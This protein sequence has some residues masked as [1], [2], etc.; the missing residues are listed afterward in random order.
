MARQVKLT[1]VLSEIAELMDCASQE[2]ACKIIANLTRHHGNT[3]YLVL[4]DQKI[5]PA[6]L[7][8]SYSK[9][10]ETRKYICFALQNL[11][12]DSCCRRELADTEDFLHTLCVR[13]RQAYNHDERLA[14]IY[15][16]KNLTEEPGTLIAMSSTPE[17]FPTLMQIADARDDN[18]TEMMRYIGCDALANLSHWFRILA[19]KAKNF[20]DEK[21]GTTICNDLLVPSLNQI[22]WEQWK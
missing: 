5:V 7:K 1:K 22:A 4:E 6:L 8:A 11:C 13:I 3:K 10:D 16:L 12:H 14:A 20:D 2:Y 21:L 9:N 18:V 15:A 17:C 19:T